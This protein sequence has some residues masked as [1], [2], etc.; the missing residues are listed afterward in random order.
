[1]NC[2]RYIPRAGMRSAV[3]SFPCAA[4]QCY[5][6]GVRSNVHLGKA[7]LQSLNRATLSFFLDVCRTCCSAHEDLKKQLL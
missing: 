5:P 1:M 2:L 6:P 7:E 4:Q 3:W